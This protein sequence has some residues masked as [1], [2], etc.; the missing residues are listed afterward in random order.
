MIIRGVGWERIKSIAQGLD[1]ILA[2]ARLVG[3]RTNAVSFKL[4]TKDAH[5]Y[6]SRKSFTGR[7]GKYVCFHGWRDF[8]RV[9]FANGATRISTTLGHWSSVESFDSDLPRLAALNMGSES[10]PV[11]MPSLC[12]HEG[13]LPALLNRAVEAVRNGV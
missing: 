1:L 4:R 8:I 10:S 13:A 5:T 12:T 7:R 6:Y 9:C 2:D 11:S 3:P